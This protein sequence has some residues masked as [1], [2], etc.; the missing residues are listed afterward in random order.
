LKKEGI[1]SLAD[2]LANSEELLILWTPVYLRRLWCVYELAMFT[3]LRPDGKVTICPLF[4][5]VLVVVVVVLYSVASSTVVLASPSIG[6]ALGIKA[7]P[8]FVVIGACMLVPATCMLRPLRRLMH[9]KR[10]IDAQLSSF[11]IHEAQ[12]RDPAD[13]KLVLENVRRWYGSEAAFN[14]YVRTDVKRY[15]LSQ[16]PPSGCSYLGSVVMASAWCVCVVAPKI[17]AAAR[18]ASLR[19]TVKASAILLAQALLLEP[20]WWRS[21]LSLMGCYSRPRHSLTADWA[22]DFLFGALLV[23]FR[24]LVRT[25]NR[26]ALSGGTWQSLGCVLFAALA[27]AVVFHCPYRQCCLKAES[28]SPEEGLPRWLAK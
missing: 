3:V 13:R 15:V 27:A 25:W 11:D 16:M 20:T 14:D 5:H 9:Q 17:I 18:T 19:S 26:L 2:F 10:Q 7:M 1:N 12:C 8:L 4:I 6:A 21:V 23:V 22:L 24:V 28:M